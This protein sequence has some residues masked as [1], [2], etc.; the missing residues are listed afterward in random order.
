MI[1]PL[2]GRLALAGRFTATVRFCLQS[3]LQTVAFLL[4]FGVVGFRQQDVADRGWVLDADGFERR[5]G[6][7]E[8]PFGDRRRAVYREVRLAEFHHERCVESL[9]ALAGGVQLLVDALVLGL[10]HRGRLVVA[11]FHEQPS[12]VVSARERLEHACVCHAWSAKSVPVV[13]NRGGAADRPR[14][15]PTSRHAFPR[16]WSTIR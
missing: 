9:D 7:G 8:R 16:G 12:Q 13:G 4:E 3:R 1:D 2:L 10:L 15:R 5:L 11:R 6:N 14:Q